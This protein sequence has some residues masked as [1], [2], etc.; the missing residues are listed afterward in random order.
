VYKMRIPRIPPGKGSSNSSK[1][2]QSQRHRWGH[3]LVP[4]LPVRYV[5][6]WFTSF[7]KTALLKI[8]ISILRN[9]LF[10]LC[11][12]RFSLTVGQLRRLARRIQILKIGQNGFGQPIFEGTY[13]PMDILFL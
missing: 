6:N 11:P 5:S 8:I 2:V 3:G 10:S 1:N 13:N 9:K 4:L 12:I 7:K